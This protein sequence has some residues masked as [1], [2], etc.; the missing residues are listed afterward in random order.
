MKTAGSILSTIFDERF[1]KKAQGYS[2][3]FDSWKDIT[4]KNGLPAAA[5]H[6]R[7]KDL[8]KGIVYIEMDHPGWKQILQTKQSKFLNDFKIRFPQLEISGI[9]LM[10]QN[11]QEN[12]TEEISTE[13]ESVKN[14]KTEKRKEIIQ[15]AEISPKGLEAIKDDDFIETLKSLGKTIASREPL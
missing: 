12:N 2:K 13:N 8:D 7:I 9:A 14:I 11:N 6:S 4:E 5:D 15:N 3:F 10:L 1:M